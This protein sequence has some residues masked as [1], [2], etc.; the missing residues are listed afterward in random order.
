MI[1]D[2]EIR[3]LL[4]IKAALGRYAV[5]FARRPRG[6]PLALET[7]QK[8]SSI[9]LDDTSHCFE[10]VPRWIGQK[11]E[12]LPERGA[13]VDLALSVSQYQTSRALPLFPMRIF[14]DF[15]YY[16]RLLKKSALVKIMKLLF[17]KLGYHEISG[18]IR[19]CWRIIV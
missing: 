3:Y 16:L 7:L 2:G 12:S 19:G 13:V 4:P 8:E 15:G 1:T 10:N 17:V 6:N 11:A 9:R 14:P 18:R 5:A